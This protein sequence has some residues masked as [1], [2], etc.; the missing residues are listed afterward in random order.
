M[1]K[2][3]MVAPQPLRKAP[4]LIFA[5]VLWLSW[6]G[7]SFCGVASWTATRTQPK[8]SRAAGKR[9]LHAMLHVQDIDESLRFYEDLGMNVLS[10]NRR[11][12]GAATAFVGF[13][14]LRDMAS[15]ALELSAPKRPKVAGDEGNPRMNGKEIDIGSFRGIT[16]TQP[17]SEFGELKD[18]DGYPI[19]ILPEKERDIVALSL[20][21]S[22]LDASTAFY[23]QKL[24]MSVAKGPPPRGTSVTKT[25]FLKYASGPQTFLC[26]RQS[27]VPLDADSLGTGFDH[28]VISTA[29]VEAAAE[30]LEEK[31]VKIVLP[32]TVMFGL[33]ITGVVDDDGYKIYLVDEAGFQK[34]T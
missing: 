33:N 23:T 24:G 27:G 16:V 5:A 29:D 25:C 7:L 14:K 4:Q 19:E 11:S 32:P 15:F 28:L 31:G 10:C 6:S 17:Q 18:P 3:A 8:V 26:L 20:E 13:G 34:S 12:N 22:D 2:A 30:Q 1:T 21:T 9:M